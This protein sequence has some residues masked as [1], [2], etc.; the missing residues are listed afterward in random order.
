MFDSHCHLDTDRFSGDLADVL[1]KARAAGIQ[2]IVTIG[3]G[4][5]TESAAA[6]LA[7]AGEHRGW[8]S[9]TA[10]IHP[11]DASV[12]DDA[13]LQSIERLLE[14]PLVVAV[15]ETGLD[16]H[17]DNSPRSLQEASFREHVRL[18]RSAGKPLVVHTRAAPALTLRI[19]K[20]EGAD[21]VG[22][23]I[24]CFSEDAEYAQE[25]LRL[26]FVSSFSGLVTFPRSIRVLEAAVR[27][28]I[29][30]L[31]VET[32]APFLAPVP[33]RG[34]RNEPAFLAATVEAIARARGMQTEALRRATTEN[35]CR[36]YGLPAPDSDETDR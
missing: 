27:Q 34:R 12:A 10:G 28:P 23:I 6:A 26:G 24:H 20:E 18:A 15:G 17:Y 29:D 19:L 4:R 14:D 30:A 1:S 13:A 5:G 9:A 11:H 25:A 32:D 3:A 31:L 36:I 21:R 16:F 7:I 33:H 8:I 2:R 35:A 22:G